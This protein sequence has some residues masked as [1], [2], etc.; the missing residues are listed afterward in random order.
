[1]RIGDLLRGLLAA[2]SGNRGRALLTL[3]GIMIGTGSIVALAGLLQG[4][5]EA[6]IRLNQGVSESD[7]LRIAKEDA[8]REQAGRAT[9]ELSASDGEAL[10]HAP[11]LGGVDVTIEARRE[12]RAYHQGRQKR[13]RLMGVGIE[14]LEM[15]RLRV[16]RGRYL[17]ARD[18]IEGRRV[19]VI[20][21]EV[22]RELMAKEGAPLGRQLRIDDESWTIVGV[23]AHKPVMGHGDGTWMWDRRVLVPRAAF[24]AT[25]SPKHEIHSIFLR[26]RGGPPSERLMSAVGHVA[27]SIVLR[28]HGGVKNFALEDRKGH[29]QEKLILTIIQVL[30]LGTGLMS[31]FVGGIN[32]MNIMLVTVTERTKEIGVRRAL[33]ASPRAILTQFVLEAAAV[34]LVGGVIGVIGGAAACFLLGLGLA[35]AFGAWS[36]HLV[37]WSIGL[38][39]ALALSTGIVFGWFP[40]WR[41]A[42]LDP[43]EAL[44]YE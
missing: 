4:A 41:A 36:F 17:D 18:G 39:L 25:F 24:D 12:S 16:E 29:R 42:R 27:E 23:L 11:E 30:L 38:G 37:P 35:Q 5:E 7:T 3:L 22:Y 32:I 2:F 28:R 44:R 40:A 14:A 19:A 34:S 1:M 13:V 6:L 20:G 21:H 10:A 15:Y 8:P 33:G 31:M 43:V 9:R 26:V